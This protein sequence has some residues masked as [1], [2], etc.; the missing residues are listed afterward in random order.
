MLPS[1]HRRN[2]GA[3]C[4]ALVPVHGEAVSSTDRAVAQCRRVPNNGMLLPERAELHVRWQV[5][6]QIP[7]ENDIAP[8][9]LVA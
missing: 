5:V 7:V 1:R 8:Y 9:G 2:R 4:L 3:L 6:R